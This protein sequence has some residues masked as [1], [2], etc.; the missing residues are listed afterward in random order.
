M[1]VNLNY[2]DISRRACDMAFSIRSR[3]ADGSGISL[4][5][6]ISFI[7][8][9]AMTNSSKRVAISSLCSFS[10]TVLPPSDKPIPINHCNYINALRYN[11]NFR[12][13]GIYSGCGYGLRITAT[14]K[15]S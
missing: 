10:F 11:F 5:V 1:M 3:E 8:P 2:R 12:G 9:L 14:A 15:P 6:Q 13:I 7:R 4:S